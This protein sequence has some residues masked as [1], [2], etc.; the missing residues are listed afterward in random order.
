MFG[1][2]IKRIEPIESVG[3]E[4]EVEIE[5]GLSL[6]DLGN[7]YAQA[8]NALGAESSGS[9]DE[10]PPVAS[11]P[12]I[13]VHHEEAEDFLEA[14]SVSETD[15]LLVTTESV[16]E[17]ILFL[18]TNDNRP[19]ETD[20]LLGLFRNMTKAEL[21][22]SIDKLNCRYRSHNR[23]FEI[24]QDVGGYRMH[25]IP[26]MEIVRERFYG[27]V[28]ETQLPQSAIDCLAIIA[29]QPGATREE[30]D[31]AWGQP[32]I[33]TLNLLIRKGLLRAEKEEGVLR[34]FTTDRFLEVIGLQSIDDLP[35]EEL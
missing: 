25:L 14:P 4:P 13:G 11:E 15:G 2:K 29:Y 26:T 12:S 35:R 5:A 22:E 6:E 30:V 7:A 18:G 33:I 21:E 17:S 24:V 31:H 9:L 19:V 10:D 8:A 27:K 3:D 28:K 16:L 34:Y 23:T 20:R 1:R 32:A